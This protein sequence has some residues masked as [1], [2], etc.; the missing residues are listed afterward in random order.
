M[1]EH[2]HCL[3]PVDGGGSGTT[4]VGITTS[5]ATTF[6]GRGGSVTIGG[7]GS[8]S[9]LSPTQTSPVP[10]PK[11]TTVAASPIIQ[12]LPV[13]AGATPFFIARN[14]ASASTAVG[15]SAGLFDIIRSSSASSPAGSGPASSAGTFAERCLCISST[16]DSAL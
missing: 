12:P 9:A 1:P 7:G 8:P 13:G 4:G 16:T 2:G 15:R 11:P 3:S 5:G 10:S 6:F 14:A